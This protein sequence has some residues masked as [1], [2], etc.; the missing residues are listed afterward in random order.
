MTGTS[1]VVRP[2]PAPSP[3][4]AVGLFVLVA[5]ATVGLFGLPSLAA[6]LPSL[7]LDPTLDARVRYQVLALALTGAV[8]V[9]ASR[10][11][12]GSRRWLSVG[13]LDA[14]VAPVRA[15]GLNPKPGEGWWLIGRNFAI[16][17]PAVT[18][19]AV[20]FQVVA[21]QGLSAA[22]ALG[23]LPWAVGL[24]V[25]NALVEELICRYG[26][27]AALADRFGARTAIAASAV[28]FG[29]VHWFGTPGQLPGVLLAG[30]L[31]WLLAKSVVETGGIGWALL[32][33]ALVD[34]PILT[35]LLAVGR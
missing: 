30:F 32:L 29:G 34:V 9:V 17:L 13:R 3:A 28:L 12:P 16:V 15:I 19:V 2:R 33:H 31:G 10:V 5:T 1:T 6:R 8:V 26:V 11:S 23:A 7:G 14:P 35:A 25:A 4:A 22:A 27:L 24:A 21:G 20:G 18:V